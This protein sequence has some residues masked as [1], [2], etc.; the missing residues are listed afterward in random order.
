[1]PPGSPMPPPKRPGLPPGGGALDMA[2][3]RRSIERGEEMGESDCAAVL[4]DPVVEAESISANSFEKQHG[5]KGREEDEATL[6]QQAV[7]T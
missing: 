2:E 7:E 6:K 1:M 4:F 5:M 3:E